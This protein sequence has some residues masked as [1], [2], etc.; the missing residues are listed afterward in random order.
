MMIEAN[1]ILKA[2]KSEESEITIYWDRQ[3][4]NNVGAAY[5]YRDGS[6]SGSL[7]FI[8]WSEPA[9]GYELENYFD[10]DGRYLGPDQHGV[11]PVFGF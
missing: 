11:Y 5:R 4:P 9:E 1:E 6:D 10:G 2:A 7:E 3:D 8:R